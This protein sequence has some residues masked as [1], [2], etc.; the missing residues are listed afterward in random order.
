MFRHIKVSAMVGHDFLN[1]HFFDIGQYQ[2]SSSKVKEAQKE[3]QPQ[4]QLSDFLPIPSL[5]CPFL[6]FLLVFLFFS[7]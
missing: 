7:S 4:L 3:K 2:Y 1:P 6:S 5:S